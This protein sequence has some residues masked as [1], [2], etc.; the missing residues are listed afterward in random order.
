[1][2]GDRVPRCYGRSQS[3][4]QRD[5]IHASLEI[6]DALLPE[7][8]S[9]RVQKDVRVRA[10]SE[11]RRH[12]IVGDAEEVAPPLAALAGISH[13][14][15]PAVCSSHSHLSEKLMRRLALLSS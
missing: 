6:R 2:E 4:E 14:R 15:C 13:V 7:T 5:E 11:K 3:N 9:R 8:G 10:T 12:P 1:M